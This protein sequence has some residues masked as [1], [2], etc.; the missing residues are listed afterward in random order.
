[1]R[2]SSQLENA[3]I[4]IAS[5]NWNQETIHKGH[6]PCLTPCG[7][8]QARTEPNQQHK[9]VFNHRSTHIGTQFC[10]TRCSQHSLR[11]CCPGSKAN[12]SR[13]HRHRFRTSSILAQKLHIFC[14]RLFKVFPP[15]LK[16]EDLQILFV[17]NRP[18]WPAL[19]SHKSCKVFKTLVFTTL[20]GILQICT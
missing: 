17:E 15:A 8:S 14:S 4:V 13:F 11:S 10:K 16:M 19:K 7:F 18:S 9:S 5:K 1:M 20:D 2:F 6:C 3:A 12:Y